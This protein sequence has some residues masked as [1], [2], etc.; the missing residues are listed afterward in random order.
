MKKQNSKKYTKLK[1]VVCLCFLSATPLVLPV[2]YENSCPSIA[3]C[4]NSYVNLGILN[5]EGVPVTIEVNQGV[6]NIRGNPKHLSQIKDY[7]VKLKNLESR[8]DYYLSNFRKKERRESLGNKEKLILATEYTQDL[9]KQVDV[10]SDRI[11]LLDSDKDLT[12]QL[13]KAKDEYDFELVKKLLIKKQKMQS[14]QLADTSFELGGFYK[15]DLQ[16]KSA[17]KNF[18]QAVIFHPDNERYLYEAGVV[19][20]L[21]GDYI[22]SLGYFAKGIKKLKSQIL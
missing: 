10:L 5:I 16:Y 1:F 8:I 6:I 2:S 19:A 20:H 14:Q 11:R 4:E 15:L 21:L 7:E 13:I 12:K 18:K 3:G 22:E 17:Y 9:L